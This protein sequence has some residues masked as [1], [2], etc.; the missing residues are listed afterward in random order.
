MVLESPQV[1]TTREQLQYTLAKM[2]ARAHSW[3]CILEVITPICEY[4]CTGM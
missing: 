4:T 2:T 1:A 3:C